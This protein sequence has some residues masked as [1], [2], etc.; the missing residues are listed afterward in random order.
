MEMIKSMWAREGMQCYT[1][2]Q[3]HT[4]TCCSHQKY[5]ECTENEAERWNE[6]VSMGRGMEW[7]RKKGWRQDRLSEKEGYERRTD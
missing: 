2:K 1:H 5:T 3:T 7:V 4:V 6:D